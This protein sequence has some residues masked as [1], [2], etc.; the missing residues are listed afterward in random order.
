L[1]KPGGG[2]AL[3]EN[4][5]WNPGTRWVMS[6]I[7]FDR[8]A[9]CLNQTET[10]KRLAEAGMTIRMTENHF[11]FPRILASLRRWEPALRRLPFGAQYVVMATRDSH[12]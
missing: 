10:R 11:Y 4:N 2:F 3:W 1:I 6:R 8:D 12:L 9:V 5:P 7:P